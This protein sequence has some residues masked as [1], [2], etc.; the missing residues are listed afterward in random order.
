ML[1]LVEPRVEI[2]AAITVAQ[3]ARALGCT[4][5]TVRSLLASGDLL[6]HRVGKCATPRGVRVSVDSVERYKRSHA[7][8]PDVQQACTVE[9]R[10]GDTPAL[11]EA[12]SRLKARG[13][14]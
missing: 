9:P 11:R 14:M 3:A 4:D 6:G 12:L 7:I 1:R 10:R 8:V 2:D 13:V 5:S